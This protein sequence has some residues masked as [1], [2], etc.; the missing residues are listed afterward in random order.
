MRRP[1]A[2]SARAMKSAPSSA[3]RTAA[4]AKARTF[5]TPRMRAM[6]RK[7]ASAASARSTA[8]PPSLPV[9]AMERPRPH[10]TFSLNS[11]VGARTAPSYTTRR[12]EFEP[13]SMT[14]MG[15]SS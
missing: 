6:E 15:S 13:I 8:S 5:F 10:S 3:S 14:P 2:F 9:V 4:V 11:G 1:H 12:T 7:R